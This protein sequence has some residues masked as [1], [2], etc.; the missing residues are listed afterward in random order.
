MA[1]YREQLQERDRL[2]ELADLEEKY[3]AE[4]EKY[5]GI[6]NPTVKQREK[7]QSAKA[8]FADAQRAYRLEEEEA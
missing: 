6:E 3:L 2:A 7:F 4:Q 8:A 1:S 5:R